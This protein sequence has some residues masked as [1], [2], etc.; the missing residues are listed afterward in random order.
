[1]R[2][3][4]SAVGYVR[5]NMATREQVEKVDSRLRALEQRVAEHG[6]AVEQVPRLEARLSA[7]ETYQHKQQAAE[8]ERGRLAD[9]A[10]WAV[11]F[12]AG[13]GALWLGRL[14]FP[15]KVP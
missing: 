2:D 10:K 7:V 9:W 13:G 3:L 14:L 12:G 6:P 4:L 8:L 15:G 5:E 11:S 1:M